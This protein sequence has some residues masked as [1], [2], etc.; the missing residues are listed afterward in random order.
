M[1]TTIIHCRSNKDPL[2]IERRPGGCAEKFGLLGIENAAPVYGFIGV[3]DGL[4]LSARL[5]FFLARLRDVHES[6]LAQI[7]PALI[8]PN[9]APRSGACSFVGSCHG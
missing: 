3:C 6:R 2:L 9:C 4:R 1:L 5:G 8:L 7:V